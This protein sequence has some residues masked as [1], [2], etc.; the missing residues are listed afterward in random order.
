MFY[1]GENAGK[2]LG[3]QI[4]CALFIIGWAS[5]FLGG[6]FNFIWWYDKGLLRV[7]IDIELQGMPAYVC[8]DRIHFVHPHLIRYWVGR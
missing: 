2:L 5:F 7:P 6:A 1:G 4:V 3:S 8:P